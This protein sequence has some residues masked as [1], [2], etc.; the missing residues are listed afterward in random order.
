MMM[1]TT[2]ISYALSFIFFQYV[3]IQL[4]DILLV[5]EFYFRYI[6]LSFCYMYSTSLRHHKLIVQFFFWPW[7]SFVKFKQVDYTTLSLYILYI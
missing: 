6:I 2:T 3:N 4:L 1:I 7:V 5:Y